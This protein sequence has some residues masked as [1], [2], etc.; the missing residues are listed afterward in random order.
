VVF[1]G[2]C[3]EAPMINVPWFQVTAAALGGLVGSF[4]G[5]VANSVQE[6]R[7]RLRMQRNI[8]CALIGEI[9]ALTHYIEN[10]YRVL[11]QAHIDAMADRNDF[12]FHYFRAERDY[13]PVFRSLGSTLGYL[14][15]PL[16]R[17]LVSWYT[18]LAIM[19]ERARAMHDIVVQRNSD[20]REH[21]V[22]LAQVQRQT[23]D[24]VVAA[25]KPLME[26]LQRI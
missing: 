12:Q 3:T 22:Q 4:S 16:P 20:L 2:D 1:I 7:V 9:A 6:S 23:L 14:P 21:A 24:E 26:R 18:S 5:F 13:M 11:V 8:A 25:A 15:T 17:D 10:N 19:L